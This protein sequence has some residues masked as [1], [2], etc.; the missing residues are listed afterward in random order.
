MK[1]GFAVALILLIAAFALY[2]YSG[3]R[4]PAPAAASGPQSSDGATANTPATNPSPTASAPGGLRPAEAGSPVPVQSADLSARAAALP[5]DIASPTNLPPEIVLRNLETAM[6]Q[7]AQA[8][9]G[10]PVGT[11]PEITSQ[12]SGNN[13]RHINFVDPAAGLRVNAA[14]EMV[15]AWGT[16]YFFHQLSSTVMEIHSAGPDKVMWTADDLVIK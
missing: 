5:P 1:K 4:K 12:L 8:F 9:G 7:Y 16:P 15:D 13:P 2:Y 6:H 10:N 3:L 14:G 11:N